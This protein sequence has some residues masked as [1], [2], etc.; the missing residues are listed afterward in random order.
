MLQLYVIDDQTTSRLVLTEVA[1]SV[2]DDI[3]VQSFADPS[4]AL[5]TMRAHGADLVV[6][7]FR[8]PAMDGVQLLRG[9]RQTPGLVDVPVMMITVVDDLPV[10]QQALEAGATDFLVKPVGVAEYRARLHNLLQLR[11][12]HR[13]LHHRASVLEAQVAGLTG[14]PCD[15]GTDAVLHLAAACEQRYLPG[16]QNVRR[17]ARYS[18][19][20]AAGFGLQGARLDH[21]EQA[22]SLADI[23]LLAVS[24]RL[25]AKPARLSREDWSALRRHTQSGADMLR[26]ATSPGLA[27]GA[28]VAGHHHER[29]DGSGY[30]GGLAGTA[31]PLEARIVA[32]ADAFNA[33]TSRRPYRHALSVE[34]ASARLAAQRNRMFDNECVDALHAQLREVEAIGVQFQDQPAAT[35]LGEPHVL[36]VQH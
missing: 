6:T 23:G 20:I 16:G 15:G 10:R 28:V 17:V 26:L 19:C 30:P 27:L 25:L 18:R 35:A 34:V 31:I 14:A 12:Q 1:R 13:A 36:P 3:A 33:M 9:M 22:A 21:L 5:A 7:D 32:V 29:W 11:R 4:A 2:A 8:M 24:P